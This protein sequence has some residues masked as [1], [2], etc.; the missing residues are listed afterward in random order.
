MKADKTVQVDIPPGVSEN[1]YLTL[2]VLLTML[3]GHLPFAYGADH[4]WLALVALMA[5]PPL[6]TGDRRIGG[7][8]A[9][10]T[11]TAAVSS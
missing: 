11:V 7:S 6:W 3:A 2:P 1:N 4:A 8:R 10:G 9:G 5:L